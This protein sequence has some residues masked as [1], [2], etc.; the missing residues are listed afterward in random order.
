MGEAI[1][2]LELILCVEGCRRVLEEIKLLWGR[3][4]VLW[5]LDSV[6]L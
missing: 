2:S 3:L 5:R 6:N 4:D 1:Q